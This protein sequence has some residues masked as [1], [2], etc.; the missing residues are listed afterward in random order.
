MK[1]ANKA[2][3]TFQGII[4]Q[5]E[6]QTTAHT[7]W[8]ASGVTLLIGIGGCVWAWTTHR[9]IGPALAIVLVALVVS[10]F[11]KRKFESV[12]VTA[13]GVLTDV[14][15]SAIADSSISNWAKEIV[16]EELQKHGYVQHYTIAELDRAIEGARATSGAL[17]GPGAEQ[18]IARY[19]RKTA[20]AATVEHI[21]RGAR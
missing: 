1:N 11:S 20:K 8:Q 6:N 12:A 4:R 18:L 15:L 9:G 10:R 21:E 7:V 17:F 16:A 2:P 3:D 14:T 19:G 5:L 13:D